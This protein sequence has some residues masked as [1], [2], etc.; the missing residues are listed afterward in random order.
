LGS[1]L[2]LFAAAPAHAATQAISISPTSI[3]LTISPGVESSGSFQVFNQGTG[4]YTFHV[5]AEPYF[6]VGEDYTPDFSP[7]PTRPNPAGW[8]HLTPLSS[9]IKA[10][11]TATITYHI[12]PPKDLK[13][14]GYYGVAFAETQ[15]PKAAGGGITLNERVG[16]LFYMNVPGD[17][18]SGGRLLTWKVG[19]LQAPELAATLRIE[20]SG[21]TYF[22]SDIDVKVKDIF[23]HTKYSLL[24]RK[25]II[26]QTIRRIPVLWPA[27]P[28]FGLFTVSGTATVNG[29]T[30]TL[31][32]RYVLVVSPLIRG[33]VL[34]VVGVLIVLWILRILYRLRLR[35]K[36]RLR[37]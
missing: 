31:P 13:P 22:A 18:P 34:G 23:G 9:V 6:P 32:T 15:L 36:R 20:N 27:T 5:Y 37:L 11:T 7:S 29:K 24:T 35:R 2:L 10:G 4:D 8:F 14:G 30:V 12:D 19:L 25:P 33:V 3:N 1:F 21:G 17:V 26:P 16:E 28:P